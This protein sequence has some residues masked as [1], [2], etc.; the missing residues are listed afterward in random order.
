M[1][2]QTETETPADP[3]TK[4]ANGSGEMVLGF[5]ILGCLVA[6]G[7]GIWK[8]TNMASGLDVFWCLLG[9]VA[10]FGTVFYIYL[11]RR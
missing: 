9:A 3:E 4:A 5:G 1:N 8:A 10:S 11:G 6:G 7:V 2:P